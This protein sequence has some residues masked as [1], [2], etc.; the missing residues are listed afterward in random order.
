MAFYDIKILTGIADLTQ[1]WER[2]REQ[3]FQ[4]ACA[5]DDKRWRDS[6]FRDHMYFKYIKTDTPITTRLYSLDETNLRTLL[7]FINEYLMDGVA[8]FDVEI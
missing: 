7:R 8:S 1:N 3:F 4:F 2:R 5:S 6:S